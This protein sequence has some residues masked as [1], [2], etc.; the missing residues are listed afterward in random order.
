M[1]DIPGKS[2]AKA[3]NPLT[4]PKSSQPFDIHLFRQP[5]AEYR[6]SPF[7]SWNNKLEKQRL[8]RQLDV[9]Q[10]MGMGGVH[11]HSRIGLDSEYLGP[12]FMDCLKASVEAVK[13]KDML[14]CLYDE[15]RWPSG[16]AGGLVLKDHPEYRSL[17]YLLTPWKY[18]EA[19]EGAIGAGRKTSTSPVRT[20]LGQF[21][22]SFDISLTKDGKLG[23][24]RRLGRNEIGANTWHLYM[25]PNPPS[26]FYNNNT[27]VDVL[28][29]EAIQHFIKTTHEAFKHEVGEDFGATVPSIFTDEPQFQAKLGLKR[30]LDKTDVFG[31]W[32]RGFDV[33]FRSETGYDVLDRFPELIWDLPD[34]LPSRAR[35][36]YHNLISERFVDSFLDTISKWCR[37]HGILMAGHMLRE[38]TLNLQTQSLGEA[39][40]CYRNMDIPG[41]D[42]LCD[43]REFTTAKQAQSVVRQNGL[44]GMVSEIYGVTNWDF[45]FE[46]HKGQGDWQAALGV[47][48]RVHHL[49]WQSMA[50]ESK[51]DY[52]AAIGYQS[53]WHE[54]YKLVEDHF[55]RLNTALTR[56]TPVC[57]VAV[58]HPIESYWLRYGPYDQCGEELAARDAVFIDLTNWLLLGHIDFD[59]I[60][61]SLFPEQTQED[62]I[63]AEYLPVGQCRYNVVIVPDLL[64]IRSTT[65]KRLCRFQNM[66]GKVIIAGG[67]PRYV[68]GKLVPLKVDGFSD[69]IPGATTIQLSRYHLLKALHQFR[70]LNIHTSEDT[71]YRRRGDRTNTLLYQMRA[72]GPDRYLFICNTDRKEACPTTVAIKGSWHLQV[73]ETQT[74]KTWPMISEHGDGWTTFNYWFD[75]CASVLLKLTKEEVYGSPERDQRPA[76]RMFTDVDEVRLQSVTLSEPNVLL[77]DYAQWRINDEPWNP[78]EE[79]LRID[80][81]VRSKLGLPFKSAGGRQPWMIKNEERQTQAIVSIKFSFESD[82]DVPGIVRLALEDAEAVKIKFDDQ[83]VPSSV[84]GWW[85]DEDIQTIELPEIRKGSHTLEVTYPFSIVTNIERVYVLGE[86][87]V[88][89]R[90]ARAL[91][92]PLQLSKLTFGDYT[93]QGLPFYAGNLTYECTFNS[94]GGGATA[95]QATRFASPV[96]AVTLDGNTAGHIAYEPHVITFEG[97]DAGEHELSITSYGN[98]ANAFGPI[99]LPNG[100][101]NWYGPNAWRTDYDWWSKEYNL[102]EMGV[103]EIPRVKKLG[104]EEPSGR[105][106]FRFELQ[107][108]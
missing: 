104:K 72:D 46:G 24:Y 34:D 42:Q 52:P 79:I 36:D 103:L 106:G 81:L 99:H 10:Q 74:G 9:F 59:F 17:H 18:G 6:G 91:V 77:L 80:N 20:E 8:L 30:A 28:N 47:T 12:E 51:R 7:W 54:E 16:W 4:Y 58:I 32:T 14:A 55:S 84:E 44:R 71:I 33:F 75:G 73:L 66:G 19:P 82:C 83:D 107:A 3:P 65:L 87:G 23:S 98:R 105:M 63:C 26:E 21:L 100:L 62:E 25:E 92:V 56:G 70:D 69:L 27:Y 86:F 64:T 94:Q 53:P 101:T 43:G 85:V 13:E 11:I 49:A 67:T 102:M 2:E 45:T 22:A 76:K 35:Y 38:A 31:P 95:I 57:R 41:M 93:H 108:I 5:T 39:M 89:V 88:E 78:T 1:G 37:S 48:L 40:R 97:L 68:D 60:S 15:D 29:K 61:E 90:G 96:L 50:G